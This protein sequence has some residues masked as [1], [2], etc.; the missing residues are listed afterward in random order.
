MAA[1]RTLFVTGATGLV[2]RDVVSRMLAADA[3]LRVVALVRDPARWVAAASAARWPVDRVSMAQG[4]V[5]L[6]GLGL[7]RE[8]RLALAPCVDAVLHC[9]ADTTFSRPLDDARRVNTAGTA[10]VLETIDAWRRVERVAHVS[11][12]YVAGRRTGTIPEDAAD[13]RHG[14]VNAYEQSKAEAEVLV[15]DSRHDWV[16]IRPSTI[17]CDA[18]GVVAQPNAVHR[19]LRVYHGGL[20]AMLP[21]APGATLDVVT[22]DYVADGVARLALAPGAGRRTYQLCAGAAAIALDE[23]LDLS[24][25]V[26]ARDADWRRRN[27]ARPA[28]AD[29][30]TWSAFTAAVEET[31]SVRLAGIVRALAHFVPQLALPKRFETATADA[32][33]G[34][35]APRVADF[36]PRMLAHIASDGWR[37]TRDVAVER[38]A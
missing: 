19:G 10:H 25:D 29:L 38:A 35:P 17:V 22:S 36:W 24:W 16:V 5:T 8:S 1:L 7:P 12:A 14:W 13:D 11:T 31:G 37:G 9:A 33:L 6:P 28:I 4:D 23:M 32:L 27:V 2:G 34:A 21:G 15:R 30:A 26:W 20:A 18:S 3:R